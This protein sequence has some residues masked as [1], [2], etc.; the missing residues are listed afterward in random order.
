[1]AEVS[2]VGNILVLVEEVFKE[3]DTAVKVHVHVLTELLLTLDG[4]KHS[5]LRHGELGTGPFAVLGVLNEL[6]K[7]FVEVQTNIK[8]KIATFLIQVDQAD[9]LGGHI[10]IFDHFPGNTKKKLKKN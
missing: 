5:G 6:A 4:S 7:L 9:T 3:G 2:R 1:M 10:S 8:V